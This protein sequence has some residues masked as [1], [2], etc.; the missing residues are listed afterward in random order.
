MLLAAGCSGDPDRGAL[1]AQG[2]TGTGVNSVSRPM[3]GAGVTAVTGLRTDGSLET[4]VFDLAGGRRL[5]SRPATMVGRLS[6]MG[7]QPPAVTGTP[8][9]GLVTAVE[10]RKTGKWNAT[11]VARDARTGTER[12]ARPVDSTFG[13][14]RCGPN[15]CLSEFTARKNAQFVALDPATGRPLWRTPGIA[16][17][18]HQ[19]AS[20]AVLFRMAKK[21]TLEARDLRTG[22]TLWTFPVDRAVGS[23]VNLSGGWAFGTA[24]APGGA[25]E[26][27][28]G[29]MA[30]Y[31]ARKGGTLS[32]YG[33]F[34][35]RLADGKQVWTRK[36][37][38]R[39]Y[40]SPNPATGL[41]ARQITPR[42]GFGA[43][44]RIDPGSG[45][46][47]A[48]LGADKAPRSLWWLS[49]PADMS[50]LGFV[51]QGKPGSA[52]ELSNGA[53]VTDPALR[54]WS[55]CSMN[56]P[57]LRITGL[58]GFY[59]IAALCAYDVATGKK[60]AAP[61][62]PPLWYTGSSD[63]WRVWRD[64]RGAV[65]GVRDGSGSA[66]GMYGA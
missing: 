23:G 24:K 15:V 57:E 52:Y 12:W 16:E 40:P 53:R 49:L 21:P 34:G 37:L 20:R 44:E 47:T 29:Y 63:G 11:L 3:A 19:D 56:P 58:R 33:F 65:H 64:E 22:R 60:A 55:F 45:R 36:R 4:S 25:G 42:G 18:E 66:P 61:G 5:W 7:V 48:T 51:V 8:G 9:K 39:I 30:P 50:K 2:W 59:P 28:V 31:Q 26:V 38:L 13:P 10:P 41:F 17:V 14:V 62:A 35:L 43:F 46:T 27:L 32:P 1:A 54:A 6:G